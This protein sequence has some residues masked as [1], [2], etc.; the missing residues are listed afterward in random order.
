MS[1]NLS[2]S[3]MQDVPGRSEAQSPCEP[4]HAPRRRTLTR[5]KESFCNLLGINADTKKSQGPKG[6]LPMER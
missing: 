1:G 4:K 5:W 2:L 3:S 6:C